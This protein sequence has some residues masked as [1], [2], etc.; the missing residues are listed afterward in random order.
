MNRVA[1][2]SSDER[3][4]LFQAVSVSR[5]LRPDIVEKDFWVCFMLNHLFHNCKYKTAFVFKG[6]TSLSK[7]YHVIERFS[8]D[9]DIILD[10]RKVISKDDNPWEDRTKTKQDQFNKMVNFKAAEF[11][12]TELVP[13]LN[14]EMER[15]HVHPHKFRRTMATNA[16]DRGMPI[17][18]V[19]KLLGHEKIDTTMQYAMVK[20]SNVKIAHKK[21]IG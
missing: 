10:W 1:C 16:I 6:G 13:C 14:C 11:Y 19:Q 21:Y 5:G 17:E 15:K 9:I 18:Q 3:R 12:A 2:L 4:E 20:Q 8:E 7:A